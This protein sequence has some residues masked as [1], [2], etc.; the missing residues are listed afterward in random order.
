MTPYKLILTPDLKVIGE[1]FT[2]TIPDQI[3]LTA[4]TPDGPT[5]A[6][7][8]GQDIIAAVQWAK[9]RNID[10]KNVYFTV[11]RVRSGVGKKPTKNDII[12]CRFAHLDIDP[13]NDGSPW[14]KDA[15]YR[16]LLNAPVKPSSVNW[17]GNGWQAFWRLK[18]KATI[19]Q[20]E[21]INRGLIVAFEG[22]KGTHNA[23]RLLR[24]PGTVNWPNKKKKGAGRV[25]VL[26]DICY[27]DFGEAVIVSALATA[28][29]APIEVAESR[30]RVKFELVD[31]IPLSPDD[32]CLSD[33]DHLR[34]LIE[35]PKALDRSA[36][37]FGF[38]CEALRRGLTGEQIIGVLLN[39]KNPI[40]DHCLDQTDPNRA[41]TRAVEKAMAVTGATRREL[42]RL[43]DRSIGEGSDTPKITDIFTVEEMLERFVFVR[44]GSQVADRLRP[45]SVLSLADFRN[46]TAASTHK[47]KKKEGGWKIV[48]CVDIWI[49]SLKRFDVDTVTFRAGAQAVTAAPDG[50]EALNTWRPVEREQAPDDWWES[51]QVFVEHVRWLFGEYADDF[52]D[53]LAHIEQ[54]PCMLPHY[55][56]LHIAPKHGMGRNWIAGVLARIWTGHVATAFDLGSTLNSAFN[57]RLA[58]KI[59]AIVDE[60]DEGNSGKA[61]QHAQT[62]KKLV[63]EETRAINPKYGRQH[64]EWNACRWLIF[65]NS[66]TALPLEKGDRRFWV[67]RCDNEPKSAE[68]YSALYQL[69]D[70]PT[71]ILSVAEYL[72]A[73]DLRNFNPGATPPVT[74][75]KAALLDRTRSE[76]E[77][78]LE[79]LVEKLPVDVVT[80]ADISEFASGIDMPRGT[81]LRHMFDRAGLKKVGRWFNGTHTLSKVTGYSV[82][83]HTKWQSAG[84]AA[85]RDE[86]E[87]VSTS[88]KLATLDGDDAPV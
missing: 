83:N 22:D 58:G 48:P 39:A 74:A 15:A 37:T 31:I 69:R 54:N 45:R 46:T 47:V 70:D 49:K 60:I 72:G 51:T 12:G 61:Y 1:F 27:E 76:L 9:H 42:Q 65:S 85:C 77:G 4:I 57:G 86:V 41:A 2:S 5:E 17:S 50:R 71:F 87:R 63:T 40:S 68:Y 20:I 33:E 56:W 30:E 88:E 36:D 6:K 34:Y 7:D 80:T 19:D 38:A 11:N 75:A 81:A 78:L 84:L 16:K 26:S 53:W 79:E 82:R 13:P 64:E 43:A 32:L 10:G 55:G 24:V 28:F 21:A 25:P 14:D 29:P 8:F 23:D 67:I 44:D 62:L 59:L 3:H 73:R 52:L 18:D 35:E 66:D